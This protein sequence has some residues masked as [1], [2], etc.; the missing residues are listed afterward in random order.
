MYSV[1]LEPES[2]D[3]C[4]I[5]KPRRIFG[6]PLARMHGTPDVSLGDGILFTQHFRAK[7]FVPA[8]ENPVMVTPNHMPDGD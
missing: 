6:V 4:R 1:N 5:F 2:F 3:N 8:R 7:D